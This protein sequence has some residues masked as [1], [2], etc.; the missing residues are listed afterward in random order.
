L[1]R[2]NAVFEGSIGSFGLVR[3]TR[4]KPNLAFQKSCSLAALEEQQPPSSTQKL[5]SMGAPKQK[6]IDRLTNENVD[7]PGRNMVSVSSKSSEM[8]SKILQQLDERASL[9]KEKLLEVK[10]AATKDKEPARLSSSKLCGQALRSLEHIN[11]SKFVDIAYNSSLDDLS[12]KLLHDT[13]KSSSKKQ[14]KFEGGSPS[15]LFAS[16]DTTPTIQ[17]DSLN[18]FIQAIDGRLEFMKIELWNNV[19]ELLNKKD[20]VLT[21]SMVGITHPQSKKKSAFRMNVAEV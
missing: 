7:T 12:G 5:L 18:K 3:K 9:H 6:C 19:V 11:S 10:I 1:K 8:A 21:H 17:E 13:R 16:S 20:T 2:S 14:E 15:K 4:Q